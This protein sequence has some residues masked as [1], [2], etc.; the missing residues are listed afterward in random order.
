MS[1]KSLFERLIGLSKSERLDEVYEDFDAQTSKLLDEIQSDDPDV[2]KGL[3]KKIRDSI[4]KD[5]TG[6]FMDAMDEEME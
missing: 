2:P 6:K 1:L 4:V 5:G 3:L